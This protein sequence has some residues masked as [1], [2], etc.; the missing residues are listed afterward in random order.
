[1][2]NKLCVPLIPDAQSLFSLKAPG[3]DLKARSSKRKAPASELG[4][5]NSKLKGPALELKGSSAELKAPGSDL[6][7]RSS[8]QKAPASELGGTK[9]EL[10]KG[11]GAQSEFK[12]NN[13]MANTAQPEF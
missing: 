5:A 6:K 8:K 2:T 9:S 11:C 1:M 13:L 10:I 12:P 4:G 3:S 7:A